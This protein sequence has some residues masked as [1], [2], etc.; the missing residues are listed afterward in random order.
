VG[1]KNGKGKKKKES[2]G[3]KVLRGGMK[4]QVLRLGQGV[5]A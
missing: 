1:K 4:K 5:V 2:I 3:C